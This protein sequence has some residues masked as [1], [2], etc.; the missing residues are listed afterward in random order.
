MTVASSLDQI[1][2]GLLL[3]PGVMGFCIYFAAVRI[4]EAIEYYTD[5]INK[6]D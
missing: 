3:G 2:W 6:E 5:N 1:A 4:A